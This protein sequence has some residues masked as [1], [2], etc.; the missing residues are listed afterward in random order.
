VKPVNKADMK[1]KLLALQQELDIVQSDKNKELEVT[2]RE[3]VAAKLRA[4]S[5]QHDLTNALRENIELKAGTTTDK[6][7]IILNYSQLEDSINCEI[8]LHKMWTPY[9]LPEC[10]H[11][12][13][14]S[15][16]KNWFSTILVQHTKEYPT[17]AL[18]PPFPAQLRNLA[19]QVRNEPSLRTQLELQVAEYRATQDTPQPTYTC[20]AC[21]EV[22][23]NKPAEV[24]ALKSVVG[25]V[26]KAMG[27]T[28]PSKGNAKGKKGARRESWDEFFPADIVL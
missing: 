7:R 13:C 6:S 16:L 27:E 22:V 23:K 12:F 2:K 5:I 10:G 1:S 17:F 15:C 8:C 20:P 19:T 21:R 24:F 28:G 26:S 3:T 4:D 14:A 25:A 9:I 18:N 11:I